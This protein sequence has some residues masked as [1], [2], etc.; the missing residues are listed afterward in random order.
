MTRRSSTLTIP[1]PR[2][3]TRGGEGAV[4]DSLTA[5]AASAPLASLP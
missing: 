2:G 4:P 5:L 3:L 1:R